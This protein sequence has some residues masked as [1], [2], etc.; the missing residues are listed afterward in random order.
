M[1][2]GRSVIYWIVTILIAVCV[3]IV[4]K[5]AIPLL[6]ALVGIMVPDQIATILALLIA[7]GVVWGGYSRPWG[8][9]AP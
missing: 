4:A 3:F 7:L 2:L 1:L 8:T 9:A 6:F 5:W